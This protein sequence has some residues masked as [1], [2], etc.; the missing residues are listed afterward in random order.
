MKR[1]YVAILLISGMLLLAACGK[2][3]GETKTATE[4]VGVTTIRVINS[5]S[6]V[7]SQMTSLA[8][9]FNSSQSSI[10]VEIETIPSGVDVQST[11]KGSL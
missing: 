10:V 6:E 2:T 7:G 11:L 5:K 8:K 4:D 1:G 9:A 3:S